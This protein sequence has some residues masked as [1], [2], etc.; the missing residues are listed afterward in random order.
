MQIH[1]SVACLTFDGHRTDRTMRL[2]GEPENLQAQDVTAD[3]AVGEAVAGCAR[4]R[5]ESTCL[6]PD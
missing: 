1:V 4:L 3:P 2:Q 5:A 6:T